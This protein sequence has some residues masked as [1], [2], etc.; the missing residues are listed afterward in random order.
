MILKEA[1][2]QWLRRAYDIALERTQNP[3]FAIAFAS[4]LYEQTRMNPTHQGPTG[5][6]IADLPPD[7]EVA[8]PLNPEESI[9]YAVERDASVLEAGGDVSQ[10]IVESMSQGGN[11]APQSVRNIQENAPLIEEQ[12]FGPEQGQTF[13]DFESPEKRFRHAVR[14]NDAIATRG[15]IDEMIDAR[16]GHRGTNA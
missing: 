10:A 6:G 1:Q 14:S 4:K 8:D 5:V 16:V 7:L 3:E 12:L 13:D 11:P 9:Q 15:V 2:T